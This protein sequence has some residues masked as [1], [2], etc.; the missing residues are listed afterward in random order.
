MEKEKK[1][2]VEYVWHSG[3]TY[4]VTTKEKTTITLKPSELDKWK[5]A[6]TEDP[7]DLDGSYHTI[8]SIEEIKE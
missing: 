2:L 3:E 5:K 7:Y 1:Y 6:F 8:T 4:G